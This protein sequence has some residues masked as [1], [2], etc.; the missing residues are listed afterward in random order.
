MNLTKQSHLSAH[1][2]VLRQNWWIGDSITY[3]WT[4]SKNKPVSNWM[5]FDNALIWIKKHDEEKETR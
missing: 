3:Q 1:W 4:D 5:T 2:D